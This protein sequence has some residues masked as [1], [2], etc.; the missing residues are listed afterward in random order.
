V[1]GSNRGVAIWIA[2][3]DGIEP[4]LD[5]SSEGEK[6]E[7]QDSSGLRWGCWSESDGVK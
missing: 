7:F 4:A 3:T 6:S 2:W 1:E 5:V